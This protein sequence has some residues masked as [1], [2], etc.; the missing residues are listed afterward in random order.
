MR[1]SHLVLN[2]NR[3]RA[4]PSNLPV[5]FIPYQSLMIASTLSHWI[6]SDPLPEEDGKD[7]IMTMTDP[8]GADVRIVGTHSS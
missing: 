5:L 1:T 4:T 6:S 3:T 7:T 2:V 8:L